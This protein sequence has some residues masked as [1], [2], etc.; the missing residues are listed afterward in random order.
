MGRLSRNVKVGGQWGYIISTHSHGFLHRLAF[1]TAITRAASTLQ[2]KSSRIPGTDWGAGR[3]HD[4]RGIMGQ[5]WEKRIQFN[6]VTSIR[7]N[8]YIQL[9]SNPH[10]NSGRY[11]QLITCM[12]HQCFAPG[13]GITYGQN[14]KGTG[15]KLKF[16]LLE[17]SSEI[18]SFFTFY[19]LEIHW[20]PYSCSS[21]I[22]LIIAVLHFI[23][24][25]MSVI[26]VVY[27][28]I[29]FYSLLAFSASNYDY[30]TDVQ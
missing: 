15:Y 3:I 13:L 6:P 5:R 26:Y 25:V 27:M 17:S 20:L 4:R 22:Y 23:Q 7:V 16:F 19:A 21:L 14:A 30:K 29:Q 11:R 28:L 18:F 10:S 12:S 1:E 2:I 8:S 9:Y 24:D